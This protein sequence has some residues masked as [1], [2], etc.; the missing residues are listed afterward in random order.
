MTTNL[1]QAETAQRN[2]RRAVRFFWS[3]LGGATLVSLIGNITNAVL[4]Y[5]PPVA[6]QI[7]AAAVPPIVLLAAVHGVALA[8][9]AGA[10]GAVYR[11][12]VAA[13][14]AI[15]IGAFTLSFSA[16]QDLMLAVGYSPALAWVFPAI[17]DSAVAVATLM[18]VALG[19]KPAR[20][21]RTGSA[22]TTTHAATQ[23]GTPPA[24]APAPASAPPHRTAGAARARTAPAPRHRTAHAPALQAVPAAGA[25][26]DTSAVARALVHAGATTKSVDQV[27]EVLAAHVDGA[28]ITRI[29]A[30]TGM[31]HKTVRTIINAATEHRQLATVG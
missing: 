23:N 7:G 20:R 9:R 1:S 13:V 16:L 24:P 30:N 4:P 18:L 21:T 28:A 3:L 26:P 19:D 5:L 6:I 8:V 25:G 31:H 15:G 12:A 17:I 11:W 22:Q 2:H 27:A 10:S 29:A 14:A